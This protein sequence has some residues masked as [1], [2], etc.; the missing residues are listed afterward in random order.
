MT[1]PKFYTLP[2]SSLDSQHDVQFFVLPSQLPVSASGLH[3][4]V[5]EDELKVTIIKYAVG[6]EYFALELAKAIATYVASNAL[7]KILP[8]EIPGLAKQA[9]EQI[10]YIVK[11]SIDS[12][13]LAHYLQEVEGISNGL[14][15]F[16]ETTDERK[17]NDAEGKCDALLP[18][19]RSFGLRG[20]GGFLMAANLHLTALLAKST[21]NPGYRSTLD[22]LRH[23]YAAHGIQLANEMRAR[24][25]SRVSGCSC[26]EV[27][28]GYHEPKKYNC[29]LVE[30]YMQVHNWTEDRPED[31]KRSCENERVNAL[32]RVVRDI[33]S[34]VN[35]VVEICTTWNA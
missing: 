29:Q 5:V 31:A 35:P 2:N 20:L 21:T 16:S 32:G 13:F 25:E 8:S 12:A 26:K 24:I 30:A 27:S 10:G 4:V 3:L 18:H 15:T 34:T 14:K 6:W 22:R 19:L 33:Q 28:Q 23:E 11:E 7:S 1:S 17:L 9:V